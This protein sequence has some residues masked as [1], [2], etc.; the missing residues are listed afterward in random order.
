MTKMQSFNS[1]WDALEEDPVKAENMKLR[2][3]L[4]SAVIE[5]INNEEMDQNEIAERLEITQL[6]VNDLIKGK[7]SEFKLD[8]LVN[9]AHKLGLH[10]SMQVAA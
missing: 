4:L 1:V 8:S 9:I 6:R 10:V 5:L 3:M 2:S 7:I